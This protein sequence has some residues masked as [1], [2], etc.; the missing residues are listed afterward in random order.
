MPLYTKDDLDSIT[1]RLLVT[2][3]QSCTSCDQFAKEYKV[4]RR[5]LDLYQPPEFSEMLHEE[6]RR[7][8]L[9]EIKKQHAKPALMA[10]VASLLFRPKFLWVIPAL[11]L[12]VF[13][14]IGF[15]SLDN[16]TED[17]STLSTLD[18][19]GVVTEQTPLEPQYNVKSPDLQRVTTQKKKISKAEVGNISRYRVRV[20]NTILNST[21]R[22]DYNRTRQ[23]KAQALGN[24]KLAVESAP[25]AQTQLDENQ[26]RRLENDS[27][28]ASLSTKQVLR[29]EIQTSN[30]NV[31]IILFSRK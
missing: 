6:I 5:V 25:Y 7:N 3:L 9:S 30:P 20:I 1:A 13:G 8:V 16:L 22:A 17:S 31:R 12:I 15:L 10:Q 28:S 11:L 24:P 29:M 19:N 26:P 23:R 2:H 4:V 18:S 21:S 14:V 27:T